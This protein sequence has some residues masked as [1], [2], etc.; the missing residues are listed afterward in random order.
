MTTYLGPEMYTPVNDLD[1]SAAEYGH[2]QGIPALV[3]VKVPEGALTDDR[4][5]S[6][7]IEAARQ[8]IRG[9]NPLVGAVITNSA[10]QVLHIGWHRG[11]GTPHAEADVLAQARAAGTDMSDAK[12]YVSLE[13]CNHT[14]KTGPCS[15]A[16]KEAGISQVFYAYPDRSAQASG[17]AEYL[18][19]HGVV[20]TYMREFAE[21][22]YALNERWFIS[23]AEKRPFI[24]VK[25]ASTLD[26]FIA[27]ADGTSKW[28][29]GSQARA[30]GHLIR[31]RA[32]AVMIG[33]RTTLLDNPSL[34][35]RDISGQRYNKQP[36]RVVMG[37]TDIPSTYKV[38][39]L[40]TRDPENYMQVYTHEPRVL[41]DELYSRGVRHLMIEGGPGMVGL[42]TGE[43]LLDELVW[44]RAPIL[45]GHGKSAMYRLITNT[46]EN[47]PRLQLDDLGMF[48]SVR[49]LG[50]DTATH[51]IPSP[52]ST[53]KNTPG[54]RRV[55]PRFTHKY[56]PEP[57][58]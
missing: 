42:F 9:A 5:M 1:Y 15:H 55:L 40:G 57:R 56:F 50:E 11:A 17:G 31:K 18:R 16:I 45:M 19:S 13:P 54:I 7:A 25:S 36:L 14:G 8:G 12:M 3:T 58:E 28:I 46:L 20:T 53:A 26:G 49:V 52:R 34:D 22:S 4:A 35:A 33:T 44:Y 2:L 51:L 39:G 29:T 37:E 23:V 41:L 6:L 27:A 43:D 38:C 10:G 48:P 32:D 21:D 24:T 47:A 30:D